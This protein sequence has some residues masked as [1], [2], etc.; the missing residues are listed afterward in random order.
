MVCSYLL[1]LF[2]KLPDKLRAEQ[3]ETNNLKLFLFFTK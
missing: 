2:R 3:Y 1:T